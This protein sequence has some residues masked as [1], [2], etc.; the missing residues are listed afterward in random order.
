M[1][2][3]ILCFIFFILLNAQ[4]SFEEGVRLFN[5]KQYENSK[6]LFEEIVDENE[7]NTDVWY[8]LARINYYLEDYDESTENFEEFVEQENTSVEQL[9]FYLEALEKHAKEVSTFSKMSVGKRMVDV[10]KRVLVFE[11]KNIEVNK[12]LIGFY[13]SAPGFVGGDNDEGL[14][15]ATLLKEF[16]PFEASK[17]LFRFHLNEENIPEAL[18][19]LTTLEYLKTDKHYFNLYN[20]LGYYYLKENLYDEAILAFLKQV[21]LAPNRANS[22]DSLGD[23]Y[24]AKD[25]IK[26][27]LIAYKKAVSIDPEFEP[28]IN[29]IEDLE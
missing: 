7:E 21:E 11:P 8:Y 3:I 14:R 22:Y 13:F 2:R 4:N 10:F 28:S 12:R 6:G 9:K 23:G 15:L 27:A 17:L 18:S 5:L 16:A 1:I 29:N 20:Q 19:I 24:K 25:D 26:N